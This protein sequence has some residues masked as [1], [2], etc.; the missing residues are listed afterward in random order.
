MIEKMIKAIY[1]KDIK[2]LKG[3]IRNNENINI[4]D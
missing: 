4:A 1:Q 2:V 3:L